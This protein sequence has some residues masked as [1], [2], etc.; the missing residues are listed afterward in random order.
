MLGEEFLEN[1]IRL[2]FLFG[3]LLAPILKARAEKRRAAGAAGRK[4]RE[5]PAPVVAE[6]IPSARQFE[7]LDPWERILQGGEAPRQAETVAE[8]S[9]AETREEADAPGRPDF[10]SA[11]ESE[12][13]SVNEPLVEARVP[14]AAVPEQL[15]RELPDTSPQTLGAAFTGLG[16]DLGVT[17]GQEFTAAIASGFDALQSESPALP[18]PTPASPS[19]PGALL[20]RSSGTENWRRALVLSELLAPPIALR[21]TH[22]GLTTPPGLQ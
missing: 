16:V 22:G 9:S 1:I 7:E 10:T 4:D 5:R 13:V 3:I 6:D 12:L 11:F 8:Q 2:V 17:Q 19:R 18:F 15:S 20:L 14:Q 21:G